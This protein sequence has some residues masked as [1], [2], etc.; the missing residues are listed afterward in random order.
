MP[1]LGKDGYQPLPQCSSLYC[2]GSGTESFDHGSPKVALSRKFSGENH[3]NATEYKCYMTMDSRFLSGSHLGKSFHSNIA[4]YRNSGFQKREL[5]RR[6]NASITLDENLSR[7]FE[8]MRLEYGT[9]GFLIS[10]K[11]KNFRSQKLQFAEKTRLNNAIWRCWHIQYSKGKRPLFCQFVPPLSDERESFKKKPLAVILEGKY[12]RRKLEA[13]S[14]EYKKL[15]IYYKK[16]SET[17]KATPL[18]HLSPRAQQIDQEIACYL[19]ERER[20]RR[21]AS[22]SSNDSVSVTSPPPASSADAPFEQML[23]IMDTPINHDI[24]LSS[25]PDTLFTSRS[26]NFGGMVIPQ[27]LSQQQAFLSRPKETPDVFQ[28][29]TLDSLQP[30]LDEFMEHFESFTNLL[31]K[32][33]EGA[34]NQQNF[35]QPTEYQHQSMVSVQHENSTMFVNQP[36]RYEAT[37]PGHEEVMDHSGVFDSASQQVFSP[38]SVNN[39]Q[40]SQQAVPPSGQVLMDISGGNPTGDYSFNYSNVNVM[41]GQSFGLQMEQS[42]QSQSGFLPPNKQHPGSP[43]VQS[44]VLT[45]PVEQPQ[46]MSYPSPQQQQQHLPSP[47]EEIQAQQIASQGGGAALSPTQFTSNIDPFNSPRQ[48]DTLNQPRKGGLPRNVSDSQLYTMDL[49][50]LGPTFQTNL[51]PSVESNLPPQ[52]EAPNLVAHLQSIQPRTRVTSTPPSTSQAKRARLHRNMS[53]S[54]LSSLASMCRSPTSP[55]SLPTLLDSVKQPSQTSSGSTQSNRLSALK[56]RKQGG[57]PRNM[58]DSSLLS[59]GQQPQQVP[60]AMPS[61]RRRKMS[62]PQQVLSAAALTSSLQGSAVQATAFGNSTETQLFNPA[63]NLQSGE[64]HLLEQLLSI[65]PGTSNTQLNAVSSVPSVPQPTDTYQS[66]NNSVLGQLLTQQSPVVSTPPVQSPAQDTSPACTGNQDPALLSQL[67][68]LKQMLQSKQTSSVPSEI[69]NA[70]NSLTSSGA[71]QVTQQNQDQ[72]TQPVVQQKSSPA[73]PSLQMKP[74]NQN[75]VTQALQSLLRAPPNVSLQASNQN[76]QSSQVS[77][78][79]LYQAQNVTSQGSQVPSVTIKHQPQ[80]KPSVATVIITP[81]G[82]IQSVQDMPTEEVPEITHSPM[83]QVVNI[84]PVTVQGQRVLLPANVNLSTLSL[85]QLGLSPAT[86]QSVA[87]TV[88]SSVAASVSSVP[89]VAT[90]NTTSKTPMISTAG[91]VTES[92]DTEGMR[93]TQTASTPSKPSRPVTAEQR[94]QYKEHRRISHI[95]AEQKRRGNIKMG[96]DQLMSLVPSLANQRN[97][98]VSKATVLQKTVEYTTKLQR[99]RQSMQEEAEM[100]RKQIQDLNTSISVCQ[101]QLPATGVP[102]ARQRA[103]QMWS[104]FNQYVKTRTQDNFKFWI[105]SVLMRQLFEEYNNMVSTVSVEEFCRTVLG[106]LEQHCS[107]PALRPAALS[108]LRDLSKATSILSDPSKVPEQALRASTTRDPTD[109]AAMMAPPGTPAGN[110]NNGASGGFS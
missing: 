57:L 58:S 11:W 54:R 73:Q 66:A 44:T 30:N 50:Q 65:P 22:S 49:S 25:L 102:V 2:N 32:S 15:R 40:L 52:L 107:L 109:L 64:G 29:P 80:N 28:V 17:P 97:A 45:S 67:Y 21:S 85:A 78:Q 5:H 41:Q 19:A 83:Q 10:P 42:M 60:P 87:V 106:W 51:C 20:R 27:E 77:S 38:G 76:K 13:V 70:L 96:F 69:L 24:A 4:G 18:R 8:C 61:Q 47:L 36:I 82:S 100:L 23:N 12:W 99:E 62:D 3:Q 14:R 74:K 35:V 101:Q 68:Q 16:W 103:D 6:P 31:V 55:P 37:V 59:L 86:L 88:A 91:S 72:G 108:S 63:G 90:V 1:Y 92:Q 104:M 84:E 33:K 75:A 53:D 43:P 110:R 89:S 48:T 94:E 105:F 34:A 98:K 79:L 7:L 39:S 81:Q 93:P 9:G 26:I 56:G 95:T 46:L 71:V